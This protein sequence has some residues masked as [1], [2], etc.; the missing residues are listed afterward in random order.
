MRQL[1]DRS[2]KR[3]RR[4]GKHRRALCGCRRYS[5]RARVLPLFAIRSRRGNIFFA[6]A[7][8]TSG[9][10]IVLNAVDYIVIDAYCDGYYFAAEHARGF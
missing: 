4:G 2:S 5:E 3:H 8:S 9:E 6:W 7:E 10:G 1:Q